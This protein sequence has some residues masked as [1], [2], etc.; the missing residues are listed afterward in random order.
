VRIGF[1]AAAARLDAKEMWLHGSVAP[2]QQLHAHAFGGF[3][4]FAFRGLTTRE[5]SFAGS[6]NERMFVR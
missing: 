4:D 2:G 6:K 3:Q 1:A 5:L